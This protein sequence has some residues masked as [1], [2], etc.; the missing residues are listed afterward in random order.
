MKEM[1][2]DGCEWRGGGDECRWRWVWW[3]IWV[4]MKIS[5]GRFTQKMRERK[6]TSEEISHP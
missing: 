3:D 6:I 1:S 4:W 2:V 5:M